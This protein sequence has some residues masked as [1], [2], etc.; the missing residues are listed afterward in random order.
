M[1]EGKTPNLTT[2]ITLKSLNSPRSN[3]SGS[4]D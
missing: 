4:S 3:S 1:M 2:G